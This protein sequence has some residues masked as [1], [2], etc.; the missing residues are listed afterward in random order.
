MTIE[1]YLRFPEI[2]EIPII[3]LT[4]MQKGVRPKQ[5]NNKTKKFLLFA[6]SKQQNERPCTARDKVQIYVTR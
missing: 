4:Q 3:K 5:E 2:A 1:K 6:L